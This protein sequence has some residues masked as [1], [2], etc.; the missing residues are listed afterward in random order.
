MT[1]IFITAS[2]TEIGKTFVACGLIGALRAQ[3]RAVNALKPVVSGFDPRAAE[4]SDPGLL[5]VALGRQP[6]EDEIALISPWRFA[7]PLSP[8]MAA[9]R[10]NRTLDFSALVAFCRKPRPGTTIIEGVGGVMAPLDDSH[11]VLDLMSELKYPVL[12]VTGSYLGAISHCLTALDALERRGLDVRSVI[13]NESLRSTVGLE[14]T[15]EAIRRFTRHDV[16]ALPRLD[17]PDHPAFVRLAARI[18]PA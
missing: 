6:S 18:T 14:E 15:A 4:T 2:G 1:A 12:L 5:L 11:T 13:V 3:G 7:A 16:V 8:D 17:A 10:E 9:R